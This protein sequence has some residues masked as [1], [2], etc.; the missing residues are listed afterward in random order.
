MF[1]IGDYIMYSL[2]GVCKVI[3]I[4]KE[5]YF[6]SDEKDYYVLEPVYATTKTVI[7][8]PVDNK[9]VFMRPII[10]EDDIKDLIDKI[11]LEEDIWIDDERERNHQ[12]KLMV[13]SGDC[14]QWSTLIKSIFLKKEE[15]KKVGKKITQEDERLMKSAEKLLNEEIATILHILPDEVPKYI[16]S[17]IS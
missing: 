14:K 10:S 17:N 15:K 13:H 2:T 5:K 16:Q 1:K 8:I 12:F 11:P 6:D 9:K 4:V 7:K 3:D